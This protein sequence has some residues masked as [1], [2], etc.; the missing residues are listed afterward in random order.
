MLLAKVLLTTRKEEILSFRNINAHSLRAAPSEKCHMR[1][2]ESAQSV[3]TVMRSQHV[4]ESFYKNEG[5]WAFLFC[6]K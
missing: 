1:R 6:K 5:I 4:Y 3:V 2:E